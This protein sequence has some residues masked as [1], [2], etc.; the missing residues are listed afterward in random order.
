MHEFGITESILGIALDKAKEVEASKIRQINLVL[1]ELAGFVPDC[2]QFY[3]DLLS[4]G[5]I[6]EE[7]ALH[8]ESRPLELRCR[9]CGTVFNPQDTM[10]FCPECQSRSVEVTGGRELYVE[11]LEVE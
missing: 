2:I 1:G 7:T 10:W 8:F 11:S 3:F 9:D 4:K 6:A 5:T